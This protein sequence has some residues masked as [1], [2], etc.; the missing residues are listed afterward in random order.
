MPG[1]WGAGQQEVR[2]A[3]RFHPTVLADAWLVE[4]EPARDPRG[5]FARTFC[6]D[7][8]ASRG[9]E[10]HYPQHS[11]SFTIKK[12]GLRGMHFNS[13]AYSEAKL[14]R[15]TR[16]A[17]WDVIID[18]RRNSP[19]YRRWQ[20]FELAS[21]HGRQLYVPK[22]FAHGFQTLCDE[23]EVSYLISRPYEPS[24]ARG[25]RYDDPAFGIQWPLPV[26]QISEKDLIWPR[27]TE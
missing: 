4:L 2:Q 23:V 10:A 24:A 16:G 15:C 8:F 14:V 20:H 19:T 22:G 21:E 12:G 9:L 17:I 1:L 11:I 18:I 26:T 5:F 6:V 27:F 3:V 13:D 7:E 25:I